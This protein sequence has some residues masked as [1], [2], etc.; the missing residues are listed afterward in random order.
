MK[1]PK[2]RPGN[3][4]RLKSGGPRMTVEDV[5]DDGEGTKSASCTWY[6]GGNSDENGCAGMVENRSFNTMCLVVVPDE[7]L[8]IASAKVGAASIAKSEA[9]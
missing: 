5:G 4:V 7:K 8:G 1:R 6:N 2:I 3:I 9:A